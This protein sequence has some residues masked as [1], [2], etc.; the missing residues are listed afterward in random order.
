[1]NDETQ[2]PR[3]TEQ[4]TLDEL[5]DELRMPHD[6]EGER[7]RRQAAAERAGESPRREG[8]WIHP[9]SH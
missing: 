6:D 3:S 1:M 7:E 9:G 8:K 5:A 2:K 4:E